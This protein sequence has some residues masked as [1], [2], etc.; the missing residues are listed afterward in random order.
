MASRN[1]ETWERPP[2]L[3]QTH[4]VNAIVYSDPEVFA[5]LRRDAANLVTRVAVRMP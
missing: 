3:P 2:D 5:D 4:F 1:R